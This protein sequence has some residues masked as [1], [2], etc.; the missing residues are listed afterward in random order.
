MFKFKKY[1]FNLFFLISLLIIQSIYISIPKAKYMDSPDEISNKKIVYLT[2][3][4]GPTIITGKLLDTLKK[5]NV[6]ATFFVVGK[7]IDEREDLLKR[8]YKEGHSIGLHT[9]SHNF[10]KI[11]KD[12]DTFLQEMLHT[13]NKIKEVTGINTNLI[14]FPG[15]SSKHLNT[16]ML[17]KLHK[18]NLKVYD[19]NVCI[20]DG[21]NPHLPV[22]QLVK[23]AKKCKLED[24]KVIILMHCNSNNINT[25]KALPQIISYYRNNGY[26]IEPITNMTP[27]YHYKIKK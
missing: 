14:R 19:W 16:E 3:D 22:N 18:N 26:K 24:D 17:E 8:I 13:Q 5:Y 10:K 2:F 4:D 23:K 12:E 27:E 1:K 7:E 15:G 6:K 20:D 11:Y 25:I 21:V 9:F